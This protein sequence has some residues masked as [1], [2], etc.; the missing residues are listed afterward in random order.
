MDCKRYN[1]IYHT[2]SPYYGCNYYAITGMTKIGQ[3][4]F[5]EHYSIAKCPFYKKGRKRR[6][7]LDPPF[8]RDDGCEDTT[9]EALMINE[10]IAYLLFD[11]KLCDND[12]AMLMNVNPRSVAKWR[13]HNGLMRFHNFMARKIEWENIDK[14]IQH[15]MSDEEIATLEH[16]KTDVI[17]LYRKNVKENTNETT[18]IEER[19]A[20]SDI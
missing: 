13:K 10:D 11:E 20:E 16:L 19:T 7:K 8:T 4:P 9:R 2:D 14:Y 5:G 12:M 18:D 17:K 1:C 6:A 15:G 3:M